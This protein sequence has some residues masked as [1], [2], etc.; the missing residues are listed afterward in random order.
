MG[1]S[2]QTPGHLPFVCAIAFVEFCIGI[3]AFVIA[4]KDDKPFDYEMEEFGYF[5]GCLMVLGAAMN[6]FC[7]LMPQRVCWQGASGLA[8]LKVIVFSGFVIRVLSD[9]KFKKVW[10]FLAVD[11]LLVLLEAMF[12]K[13]AL[14]EMEGLSYKLLVDSTSD[15]G[16][17]GTA[18][19]AA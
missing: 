10:G 8:A 11:I 2:N 18:P 3:W 13:I 19:P 12:V 16:G 15:K 6:G 9:K 7:V 1:G 5:F 17:Y 14:A 4:D